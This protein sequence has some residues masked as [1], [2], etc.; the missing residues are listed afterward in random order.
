MDS[1]NHANIVTDAAIAATCTTPGKTEGSHCEACDTVIVAQQETTAL[2]HDWSDYVQTT[3]PTCTEAGEKTAHCTRTDCDATDVQPVPATGHS[4]GE[5]YIAKE[6]TCKDYGYEQ[7]DCANCDAYERRDLT[8]LAEHD[9][10]WV[11][12]G[13]SCTEGVT[14]QLKCTV[15]GDIKETIT[16]E[17]TGHTL[18]EWT[19]TLEPGCTTAGSRYAL[20]SVCGETV[21]ESIPATGHTYGEG[22]LILHPEDADDGIGLMR[23]TCINCGYWYDREI[24]DTGHT[25]HGGTATCVDRAVCEECGREYGGYDSSNHVNVV[26]MP[27]A[28]ATCETD[29]HTGGTYCTACGATVDEPVITTPATGHVD[30]DGDG[31]CDVDGKPVTTEDDDE[32]DDI[33]S[34]YR[35]KMCDEYEENKDKPFIGFFYMIIHFFVH[36]ISY[37][38]YLT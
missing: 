3:D 33:W 34:G 15:C 22:V 25:H 1:E 2:G 37:I 5:W 9:Y 23:Y 8:E 18:G 17:P 4:F 13:G 27:D 29:G 30:A 36:L 31:I 24:T 16:E 20:C 19:V 32:E 6:S 7:R 12:T 26:P 10:Q 28:E 38:N 14:K 11:T 35:C 21:T